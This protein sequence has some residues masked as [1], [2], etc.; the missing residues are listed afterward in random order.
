M[1]GFVLG[2]VVG[3]A[4]GCFAMHMIHEYLDRALPDDKDQQ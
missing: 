3:F 2:S 4:L 1:M